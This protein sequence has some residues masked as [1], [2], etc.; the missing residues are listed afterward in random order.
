M[1]EPAGVLVID[2][3][4]GLTSHDVVQRVR[5]ATGIRRVGHAGTL[6]PLATGLLIVCIGW[7]T[8]LVEYIQDG[9]KTYETTVRLGQTTTTYD[10]EGEIVGESPV[11][12]TLAKLEAALG[13]FRGP[14]QQTAPAYSA[15]KRDGQPL[16]KAARRGETIE[17]PVRPVTIYALEVLAFDSPLVEL[18]VVCSPGTYIRSLAHDLGEALGCGGHVVALRRTASGSFTTA[19]AVSLDT[20][21]PDTWRDHLL[22]PEAA[23]GDLP[24]VIVSEADSEHL[25][26]GRAIPAVPSLPEGATA[27]AFSADG[28]LLGIVEVRADQIHPR[29][30]VPVAG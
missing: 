28:R 29:K 3:P 13:Q 5:R 8:R 7:A 21:T 24:Q 11:D 18:R 23:V 19:D 25:Q 2:K 9:R 1:Q 16:Y 15:I 4:L 26:H 27:A 6:D 12:V 14:I 17:L 30:I 20:L 10:A 22:S